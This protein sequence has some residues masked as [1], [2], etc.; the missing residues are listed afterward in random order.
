MASAVEPTPPTI[1]LTLPRHATK[2]SERD[3]QAVWFL[4]GFAASAAA[5]IA[6]FGLIA[7]VIS[8][9]LTMH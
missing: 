8:S 1:N 3:K 2:Q 7:Y 4:V 9:L 5:V 6:T